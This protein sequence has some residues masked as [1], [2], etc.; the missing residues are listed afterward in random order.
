MAYA[1]DKKELG[2]IPVTVV[3]VDLDKCTR[4]YGVS[5]CTASGSSGNECYNTYATCQDTANFFASTS[6]GLSFVNADEDR[7]I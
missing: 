3:E 1:T 2:K 5:P 7:L 6:S 4:T